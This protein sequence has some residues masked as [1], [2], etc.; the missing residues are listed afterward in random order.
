MTSI[1]DKIQKYKDTIDVSFDMLEW[2][3]EMQYDDLVEYIL[4]KLP[5]LI[6]KDKTSFIHS[7]C[8]YAAKNK[9]E[10]FKFMLE[11]DCIVKVLESRSASALEA[12]EDH[13]CIIE[14]QYKN[15]ERNS[16]TRN[17]ILAY[18]HSEYKNCICKRNYF[19]YLCVFGLEW[20]D[21]KT[22]LSPD[23]CRISMLVCILDK[24]NN[25]LMNDFL[26]DTQDTLNQT[27]EY[28][29]FLKDPE[30]LKVMRKRYNLG[31][32]NYTEMQD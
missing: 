12:A 1:S 14:R 23:Y 32:V 15:S 7:Y 11:N 25:Q 8:D 21:L 10:I 17:V 16:E 30:Y 29:M 9:P 3:F 27:E 4:Q 18:L 5:E 28:Q 20:C 22:F 13:S 31:Y 26:V 19:E 24:R 6:K 2:A